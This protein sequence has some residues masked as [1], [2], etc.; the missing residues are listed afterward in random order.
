MGEFRATP[1]EEREDEEFAV[2][3]CG[4]DDCCWQCCGGDARR[5]VQ[6]LGGEE[7]TP[8]RKMKQTPDGTGR[9]MDDPF[10]GLPGSGYGPT[11]TRAGWCPGTAP[12][13]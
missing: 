6:L 4:E 9:R 7:S 8:L 12:W 3:G 10:L 1:P 5:S 13:A 2:P 11:W